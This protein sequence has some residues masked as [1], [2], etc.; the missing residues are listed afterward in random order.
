MAAL[1]KRETVTIVVPETT[2]ARL[3]AIARD[4]ERPVGEIVTDLLRRYEDAQFW[5]AY[6]ESYEQLRK[7]PVAWQAYQ[8]ELRLFDRTAGDGLSG[9]DPNFTPEELEEIRAGLAADAQGR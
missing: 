4:Q 1:R 8:D 3:Q 2:H 6:R 7:D 5:A 9:H